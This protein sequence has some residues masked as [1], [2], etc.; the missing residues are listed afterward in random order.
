M[1]ESS[2]Y[3]SLGS[4]FPMI[5]L[6]LK[7]I[8]TQLMVYLK[9]NKNLNNVFVVHSILLNSNKCFKSKLAHSQ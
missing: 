8:L 9:S 3:Q 6:T 7:P 1:D 2:R 5:S 4:L